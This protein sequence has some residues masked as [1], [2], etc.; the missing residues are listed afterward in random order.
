[1]RRRTVLRVLA[2]LGLGPAARLKSSAQ[3]PSADT[4]DIVMLTALAEVVLPAA[5]G[6]GGRT[7][8]AERFQRWIRN[9]REGADRGHGY[10]NSTLAAPAGPSPAARY[11]AQVAALDTAA[12][13]Q[14]AASFAA[15]S[16]D[17]RRAIVEAKLNEPS[18]VT[19][20]PARPTGTNLV[21]DFMGYYFTSSDAYD[22]A[23]NAAIGRERCRSLDGSDQPPAPLG[24]G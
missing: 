3:T 11:P 7:Q 15:L 9:Y 16:L 8:A 4:P 2:A 19:T 17:K 6:V 21:A 1:M 20:L 24:R 23:Y 14:G 12:R 18:R 5:L 10:G 13:A 22:V